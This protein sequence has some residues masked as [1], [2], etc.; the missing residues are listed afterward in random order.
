MPRLDRDDER[1]AAIPGD[2]PDMNRLPSGCPFA[3]RCPRAVERC[4]RETPALAPDRP[5]RMIACHRPLG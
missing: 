3:P 2:P 1:L 5:E 4:L